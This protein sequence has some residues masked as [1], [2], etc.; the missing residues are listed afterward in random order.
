MIRILLLLATGVPF[1]IIVRKSVGLMRLEGASKQIVGDRWMPCSSLCA[2][3]VCNCKN[4][5]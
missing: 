4:T 1:S 5:L 3:G 2:D